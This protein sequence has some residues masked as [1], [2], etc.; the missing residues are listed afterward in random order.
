MSLLEMKGSLYDR[1]TSVYSLKHESSEVDETYGSVGITSCGQLV[2]LPIL[3]YS[4]ARRGRCDRQQHRL[5]IDMSGISCARQHLAECQSVSHHNA[6]R[7]SVPSL[8]LL[9]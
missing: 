1:F 2:V 6:V 9:G 8:C 4:I 5:S 7:P 3:I